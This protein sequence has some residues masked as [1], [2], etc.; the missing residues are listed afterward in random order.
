MSETPVTS[1]ERTVA[2]GNASYRPAY[3]VVTFGMLVSVIV[4]ALVL[5]EA[6][7]DLLGLVILGGGVAI[8]YQAKQ[9]TLSGRWVIEGVLIAGVAAAVGVAVLTAMMKMKL[10]R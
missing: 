6:S 8:F 1:D 2:V 3:I 4:R 10:G 9:R 5:K 7:W